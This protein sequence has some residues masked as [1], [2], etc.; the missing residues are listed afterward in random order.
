MTANSLITLLS[1]V[2]YPKCKR[3]NIQVEMKKAFSGFYTDNED[4]LNEVRSFEVDLIK[5]HDILDIIK[6][7]KLTGQE[8]IDLDIQLQQK[9]EN[10]ERLRL[11]SESNIKEEGFDGALD[12]IEENRKLMLRDPQ[13]KKLEKTMASQ[14][15]LESFEALNVEGTKIDHTEEEKLNIKV[16]NEGEP[17]N[18]NIEKKKEALEI[19]GFSENKVEKEEYG[20]HSEN[21]SL[22]HEDSFEKYDFKIKQLHL[23]KRCISWYNHSFES[24]QKSLQKIYQ[25]KMSKIKK[26]FFIDNQRV[27]I[28]ESEIPGIHI[29]NYQKGL[30]ITSLPIKLKD[31]YS[32]YLSFDSRVEI[33]IDSKRGYI[34]IYL[35]E[36]DKVYLW[37][38]VNYTMEKIISFNYE[39]EDTCVKGYYSIF[40]KALI[41]S[42]G[43]YYFLFK[44]KYLSVF[45]SK[46][47]EEQRTSADVRKLI[48]PQTIWSQEVEDAMIIENK[49]IMNIGNTLGVYFV[50]EENC[51]NNNNRS[52]GDMVSTNEFIIKM[53]EYKNSKNKVLRR[54]TDFNILKECPFPE[55][56]CF[57]KKI[58]CM[59]SFGVDIFW[60]FFEQTSSFAIFNINVKDRIKDTVITTSL[61]K[62]F[63]MSNDIILNFYS[64]SPS[65]IQAIDITSGKI[66]RTID[67]ILSNIEESIVDVIPISSTQVIFATS[68]NKIVVLNTNK[69]ELNSNSLVKPVTLSSPIDMKVTAISP[70]S[71]TEYLVGYASGRIKVWNFIT[72]KEMRS[73]TAYPEEYPVNKIGLFN[74]KSNMT[75]FFTY[76]KQDIHITI[77]NLSDFSLFSKLTYFNSP[78]SSLIFVPERNEIFAANY[79][80]NKVLIVNILESTQSS[81]QKIDEAYDREFHLGE[82]MY[83]LSK[84]VSKVNRK[85]KEG[86]KDD[87]LEMKQLIVDSEGC[88]G[89]G[90]LNILNCVLLKES[91]LLAT[92]SKRGYCLLQIDKAKNNQIRKILKIDLLPKFD[93]YDEVSNIADIKD[94]ENQNK[95]KE[96]KEEYILISYRIKSK[97]QEGDFSCKIEKDDF[98]EAANKDDEEDKNSFGK[99]VQESQ[100]LEENK[101]RNSIYELKEATKQICSEEKERDLINLEEQ[102]IFN[103][104]EAKELY[105]EDLLMITEDCVVV[106][107]R[108]ELLLLKV[109]TKDRKFWEFSGYDEVNLDLISAVLV[110]ERSFL[111]SGPHTEIFCFDV[112]PKYNSIAE[113]VPILSEEGLS[114]PITACSF[115]NSTIFIGSNKG[116]LRLYN[117]EGAS[118]TETVIKNCES[119][120]DI[121][122]MD[123]NKV[124]IQDESH[125]Y[126]FSISKESSDNKNNKIWC[127]KE[128]N[129]CTIKEIWRSK[130]ERKGTI[131]K[132]NSTSFLLATKYLNLYNLCEDK[133]YK[134]IIVHGENI[135]A[136]DIN[137]NKRSGNNE[138][139]ITISGGLDSYIAIS[140][141]NDQ[142]KLSELYGHRSEV[143]SLLFLN[144]DRF[145]SASLDLTLR[146]W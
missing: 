113:S 95:K 74:N 64:G 26:L 1:Q 67:K 41:A 122:D 108:T 115:I 3:K 32:T 78:I 57:S 92:T 53:S 44:D 68:K 89:K 83:M 21:N 61:Y 77:W 73:M 4:I 51:I 8:E 36:F 38:L 13:R 52:E 54:V 30:L 22:I 104:D 94:I 143:N 39:R 97:D 25:T 103:N 12:R 5:N 123:G 105:K 46:D 28:M 119:I 10:Q 23:E 80:E 56:I 20:H 17:Q 16:V 59:G 79:Q 128:N 116:K 71:D 126:V 43:D 18:S 114:I 33:G 132:I 76:S 49:I 139:N 109:Y 96:V 9:K 40:R 31:R 85:H 29:Y 99:I 125:F 2:L 120:K 146:L 106:V 34:L 121:V 130:T 70:V 11:A 127:T 135:Y 93:I 137:R 14:S 102:N 131:K 48:I 140:S 45:D 82:G 69:L 42:N 66:V 142:V 15:R 90:N 50:E 118:F 27:A 58:R 87:G 129:I 112:D 81:I 111:V 72:Q 110:K 86:C 88:I 98:R 100:N 65:Y 133:E 145:V 124:L 7:K 144:E 101:Q 24:Q 63:P 138:S 91:T 19:P 6:T 55:S 141:L 62:L 107:K 134:S 47:I 75:Q 84:K 117:K 35:A 136:L 37:N 60:V